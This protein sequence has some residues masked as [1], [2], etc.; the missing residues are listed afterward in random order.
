MLKKIAFLVLAFVC[1]LSFAVS[2]YA[3]VNSVYEAAIIKLKGDVK[4]DTK[5]DGTW[6]TPWVGMKLK[7]G[8]LLKAGSNSYAE[9]VYDAE[10][11][12][13]LKINADT[14]IKVTKDNAELPAGSVF[15]NFDNLK[16][17][18]SFSVKTPTAVCG[19]RGSGMGVDFIQG[20]TVVRAFKDRVYVRGLDA[21]GNAVGQEVQIPEGWKTNVEKDG[22]AT[23]PAE[24]SP[25]E[26]KI[27]EAWVQTIAT[28]EEPA[29][30]EGE[31][32]DEEADDEKTDEIL[33][34]A[35]E[36]DSLDQV[37]PKDID[38][39]KDVSTSN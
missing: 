33:D 11:L 27:Y 10:G 8:S 15:A 22:G 21:Q 36:Q 34:D 12:N 2:S 18:S 1:V 20:L 24:L 16:P 26:E 3:S 37:D 9:I 23:P 4:V 14:Q 25:N 19:I 17:G 32:A 28:K 39:T 29:E 30:E 31:D 7:E 13:V 5:G 38:D 6:I 35:K